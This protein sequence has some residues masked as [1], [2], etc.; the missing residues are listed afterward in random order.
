M[1]PMLDDGREPVARFSDAESFFGR[2]HIVGRVISDIRPAACD[3]MI[4]NLAECD[5]NMIYGVE[6]ASRIDCAVETDSQVCILFEDGD[7]MEIE[8][9]GDGPIIL[10]FNTADFTQYPEY[11]ALVTRF[12]PCAD[13]VLAAK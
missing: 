7:H 1:K 9:P 5:L 12:L 4:G 10:G 3:S 2:N 11:A 6:K 8:I 13:T